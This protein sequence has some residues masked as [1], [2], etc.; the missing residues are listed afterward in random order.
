MAHVTSSPVYTPGRPRPRGR[1]GRTL[2][3]AHRFD[4]SGAMVA[5]PVELV[6]GGVGA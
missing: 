6:P 1:F 4:R 5:D 2:G 3:F